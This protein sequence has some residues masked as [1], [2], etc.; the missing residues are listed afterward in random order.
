M[1]P[2]II[3]KLGDTLHE[4]MI[5]G[6]LGKDDTWGGEVCASNV[7]LSIRIIETSVWIVLM[8]WIFYYFQFYKKLKTLQKDIESSN[9]SLIAGWFD[10]VLAIVA[11]AN[12]IVIIIYK[13]K[14]GSLIYMLQPCHIVTLVQAIAL[15]SNTPLGVMLSLLSLPITVG[16]GGAMMF[17]AT[18]GLDFYLEFEMFW[19]QHIVIQI[20]PLYMLMKNNSLTAHLFDMKTLMI[21]NWILVMTHWVVFEVIVLISHNSNIF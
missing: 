15:F 13:A 21:G 3:S 1:A 7:P 12:Y 4:Y 6:S 18:S 9:Q 5:L 2:P 8:V 19:I 11:F 17:P 14:L 16:S 20:L 10:Y